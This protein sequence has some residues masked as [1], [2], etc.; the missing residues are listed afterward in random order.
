LDTHKVL[1]LNAN[2]DPLVLDPFLILEPCT[3]CHHP[4]LLLLDKFSEKKITYLG[5]E[6]GHKPPY[7]NVGKLPLALREAALGQL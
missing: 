2:L 6:S 4:E 5:N 7:T 1:Y 3:E